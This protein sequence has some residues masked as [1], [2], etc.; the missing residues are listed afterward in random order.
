MFVE[1]CEINHRLPFGIHFDGFR[2]VRFHDLL[3]AIYLLLKCGGIQC[4]AG[5]LQSTGVFFA[6][7]EKF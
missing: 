1:S 3:Q 4:V 5:K 6:S 2:G 7:L